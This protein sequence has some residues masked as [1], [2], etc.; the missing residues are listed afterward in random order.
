MT[1]ACSRGAQDAVEG[2]AQAADLLA[3]RIR[4]ECRGLGESAKRE[5][6]REL[7]AKVPA[8]LRAAV[9]EQLRKRSSL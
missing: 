2:A 8:A 7:L 4:W 9:V 5:K 3:C 6:G 1:N